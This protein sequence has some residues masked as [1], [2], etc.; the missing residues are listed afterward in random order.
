MAI[1]RVPQLTIKIIVM[2]YEGMS[3]RNV[4]IKMSF[5]FFRKAIRDLSFLTNQITKVFKNPF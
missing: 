1:S 5:S 4:E 3:Y 2:I